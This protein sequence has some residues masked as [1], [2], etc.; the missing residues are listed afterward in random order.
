MSKAQ[1]CIDSLCCTGAGSLPEEDGST[2]GN[3][4][5]AASSDSRQASADQ[6]SSVKLQALQKQLDS[7]LQR[8]ASSE[9]AVESAKEAAA[10]ELALMRRQ[11]T[12]AQAALAEAEQVRRQHAALWVMLCAACALHRHYAWSLCMGNRKWRSK[13]LLSLALYCLSPRSVVS[14]SQDFDAVRCPYWR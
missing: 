11:L 6:A 3:A 7:A 5:G 9:K 8:A 10:T 4:S 13:L 12:S 2:N 1:L 14:I